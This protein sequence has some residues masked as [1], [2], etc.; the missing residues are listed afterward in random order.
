L[1]VERASPRA[2]LRGTLAA[3]DRLRD[4]G[5]GQPDAAADAVRDFIA[6][7]PLPEPVLDPRSH[8]LQFDA[9]AVAG[10]DAAGGRGSW[11][12]TVN[13][14]WEGR[15]SLRERWLDL[16]RPWAVDPGPANCLWDAS[17]G[18]DARVTV[19]F[20]FER[21][22]RTPRVKL[23]LQEEAF[24]AGIGSADELRR[25]LREAA[26]EARWPDWLPRERAPEVL[27]LALTASGPPLAKLYV[28]GSTPVSAAAGAPAAGAAPLLELAARSR[29]LPGGFW[30]LTV[31]LASDPSGPERLALNRI[32]EP[33]RRAFDGGDPAGAAAAWEEVARWFAQ[34][35]RA[36]ELRRLAPSFDLG[37]GFVV[38]PTAL[39]IE[40][41]SPDSR[42]Q[43]AF[44]ADCYWAAWSLDAGPTARRR[45]VDQSSA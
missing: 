31:R 18:S 2:H 12:V 28:G 6:A 14:R 30:Y 22:A 5:G 26:P 4:L 9:Y 1:G 3:F 45:S 19:A 24:G 21:E 11:G 39:A 32:G 42:A 35:G 7:T 20:G 37:P 36:R 43:T 41:G 25:L 16:I 44:T 29:P 27:A 40:A 23:Y 10:W 15:A 33:L 17:V 13:D 8:A 34:A 38:A